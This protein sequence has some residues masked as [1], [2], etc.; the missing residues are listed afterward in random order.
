MDFVIALPMSSG[1]ADSRVRVEVCGKDVSLFEV[2]GGRHVSHKRF[3]QSPDHWQDFVLT[4]RV[5]ALGTEICTS[6]DFRTE[7]TEL[8]FQE[9][10]L[11]VGAA[12]TAV[13]ELHRRANGTL[14]LLP[15]RDDSGDEMSPKVQESTS[16]K[17]GWRT[18]WECL[19]C[20]EN[21][22]KSQL[23]KLEL[24]KRVLVSDDPSLHLLRM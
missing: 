8:E 13:G 11:F 4:H 18:S 19:G 22:K 20:D 1:D 6:S 9:L 12:V 24:S 10:A 23:G 5:A 7:S 15:Y 3:A 16:K 17:V 14:C 21:S 2:C